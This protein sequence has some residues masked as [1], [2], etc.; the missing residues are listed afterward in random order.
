M[1]LGNILS[2]RALDYLHI[3]WHSYLKVTGKNK[4]DS[5]KIEMISIK[6]K[7]TIYTRYRKIYTDGSTDNP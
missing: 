1:G 2:A 5:Q 4:D 3:T 7:K 6:Y